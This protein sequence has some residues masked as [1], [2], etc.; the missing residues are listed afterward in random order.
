MKGL[1]F[2]FPGQGAQY[3][4]MGKDLCQEFAIA[5]Q[6][7]EEANDALGYDLMKL[8]FEGDMEE[9]TKTENT[10]PAILTNSIASFR[11]YM[12]E[13]GITP[14]YVAGHSLGEFSAL[15]SS[16]A[17]EFR[18][19]VKIVNKRGQFMQE[20]VPIGVGGMM[21]VMKL[22]RKDVDEV[23]KEVSKPNDVV[24]PANYNSDKQIV[25]S[26]HINA[27]KRAGEKLAELGGMVK[28]L[29]V[30]A[31][32]HS[33]L[34]LPTRE[35]LSEELQKYTFG[36]IKFPVISN[37]NAL[38]YEGSEKIIENLANQ[39]DSPVRWHESMEYI[40]KQGIV[41]AIEMGPKKVLKSLMKRS[42]KSIEVL[43]LE[44][45]AHLDA[46]REVLKKKDFAKVV[47]KCL[48]IVVCTRN[49]NWDDD[50]YQ[51]GVVEPYRKIQQL[52]AQIEEKGI[53]TTEE[54]ARKALEMLKMV[55]ETKKVP[56][57]EQTERFTEVFDESG[58]WSVFPDF[59]N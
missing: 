2:I 44:N 1:A 22:D 17:L 24:V 5:K 6:T 38:P 55:F 51:K 19:A 49:R 13:I 32:F 7:F 33:P 45:K 41:R 40:H 25:I 56:I 20:A 43:Q 58:T 3:V 11:V 23:C 31:P 4:G 15:V 35:R 10:Q 18:D 14:E 16:G 36:T 34:M 50:E 12:Q 28:L 57:E 29:Q 52:Q 37:V 26:G 9:L 30:S 48:A 21:A 42:F 53:E 8:C 39:I 59:Q 54:D 27:V 46:V 47:S